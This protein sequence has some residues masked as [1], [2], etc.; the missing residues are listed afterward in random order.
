[1]VF[2]ECYEY[3]QMPPLWNFLTSNQ[4]NCCHT[5]NSID[6]LDTTMQHDNVINNINDITT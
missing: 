6:R 4:V 5:K 3:I 1:M 2:N